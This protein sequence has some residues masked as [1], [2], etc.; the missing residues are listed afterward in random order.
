MPRL[1]LV[2]H[3]TSV[4]PAQDGPGEYER[5]LSALGR[6]QAQALVTELVAHSPT[7]V[8]SS[9][10]RRSVDTVAPTARALGLDV[11]TREAL[12]EWRSG[13]GATPEWKTHYRHCWER[14]E[15]AAVGGETHLALERR[16]VAA[17]HDIAR[18]SP[19]ESVTIVGSHGGWIAR[20]LHG[21]GWRIDADFW[22][23]MPM[24]AVFEVD[25]GVSGRCA[26]AG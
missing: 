10:Y 11:E 26:T 13:I 1:L 8:L 22:L 20:A 21:L 15:S 18:E 3:A 7:R 23:G 14:P 4:P 5:P 24:P 25:V 17:L 6:Q 16:A 2:R 19:A 12:R 9:P